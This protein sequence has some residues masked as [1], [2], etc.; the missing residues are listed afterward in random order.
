MVGFTHAATLEVAS[1]E[2]TSTEV[3]VVDLTESSDPSR[4]V[5]HIQDHRV[6]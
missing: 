4:S 2:S 3:D 5:A 1:T 6:L